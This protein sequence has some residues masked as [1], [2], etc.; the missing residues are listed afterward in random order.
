MT[1]APVAPF[2]LVV[3][4]TKAP[5][6]VAVAQVLAGTEGSGRTGQLQRAMKIPDYR[7]AYVGNFQMVTNSNNKNL[8]T[9]TVGKETSCIADVLSNKS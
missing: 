8:A 6:P 2:A 4:R 3:A 9:V 7:S 1:P 5:E